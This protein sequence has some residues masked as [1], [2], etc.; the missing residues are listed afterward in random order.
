TRSRLRDTTGCSS[1]DIR[2]M[3]SHSSCCTNSSN[4]LKRYINLK[5]REL[6]TP[7]DLI[8]L[9]AS[10]AGSARGTGGLIVKTPVPPR[11]L[12]SFATDPALTRLPH[13][14]PAASEMNSATSVG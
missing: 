14:L 12:L 3:K 1:G 13:L 7:D 9:R 2:S 10:F 6:K 8:E 4:E 11:C 5:I